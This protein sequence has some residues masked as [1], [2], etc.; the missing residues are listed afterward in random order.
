[1]L[2]SQSQKTGWNPA[3]FLDMVFLQRM[4]TIG[5]R[6]HV[7]SIFNRNF[8]NE[9]VH[10][11]P[12]TLIV[13]EEKSRSS[14]PAGE[15][16]EEEGGVVVGYRRMKITPNLVQIGKSYMGR[17]P[18]VPQLWT[19]DSQTTHL[20]PP[21]LV[22][23]PPL[24]GV[25]EHLLKCVEMG[26]MPILIGSSACGKTSL[27]KRL[28]KLK[29]FYFYFFD[30]FSLNFFNFFSIGRNLHIFAMN[31]SVDTMELL[32]GYEQVEEVPFAPSFSSFFS[33]LSFLS[34][35]FFFFFFFFFF[36]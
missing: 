29:G 23:L 17:H 34:S 4:R 3:T 9:R 18:S 6:S 28:A 10:F 30:F 2:S 36:F 24:L 33:L 26:W 19:S 5:D 12:V 8:P 21:P 14:S 32:G 1:M 20:D 13:T 25:T 15:R 31:S 35:L 22:S 11:C 16:K 7:V 27:V